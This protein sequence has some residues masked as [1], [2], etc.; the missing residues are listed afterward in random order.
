MDRN[1]R[2]RA[3]PELLALIAAAAI[4]AAIAA[5]AGCADPAVDPRPVT[6]TLRDRGPVAGA[7]V[8]FLDPDGR[9]VARTATD[10]AGQAS[11]R[12]ARGGSVTV[13]ELQPG[14]VDAAQVTT[15]AEVGPGDAPILD[16]TNL[17]FG[18][19]L[20]GRAEVAFP[21]ALE[22]AIQYLANL[23]CN[24]TPWS[25]ST[26][27]ASVPLFTTCGAA[28]D[29]IA[30]ARDGQGL[31]AWSAVTTVP[32]SGTAP[33]QAA[34][35]AFGPW[36]TDVGAVE[37]TLR[38]APAGGGFVTALLDPRRH[39]FP[40]VQSAIGAG[41][42]VAA[43][44]DAVL[45]LAHARDFWT[46]AAFTI[47]LD[48][49]VRRGGLTLEGAPLAPFLVDLDRTIPPA[50]TDLA[51]QPGADGV[52]VRWTQAAS[53]PGLSGSLLFAARTS[54]RGVLRWRVSLPPGRTAFALPALPAS[55][56][57]FA[58]APG[59]A[60][61]EAWVMS[62]GVTSDRSFR[63][64]VA[65]WPPLAEVARMPAPDALRWSITRAP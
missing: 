33:D 38:N 12:V 40:Y 35:V 20:V 2:R 48:A 64:L 6:L 52:A 54:P 43:G 16:R 57:D 27:P 59:G 32:I 19:Q 24:C 55:V 37:V 47:N 53:D 9:E 11:A 58:P 25:G 56:A 22:G 61:D 36:R 10:A 51:V 34:A 17:V 4:L 44:Q 18:G 62:Y 3:A 21:G 28:L 13:V 1:T 42:A 63:G 41:A 46:S 31:L 49:G 45:R 15:I 29:G 7:E 65:A 5:A 23:G 39:G 50:L 14:T 26:D 30:E 8:I 60:F